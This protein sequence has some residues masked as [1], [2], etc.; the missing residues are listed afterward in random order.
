MCRVCASR[1]TT[2]TGLNQD[3]PRT[4]PLRW[5]GPRY[6]QLRSPGC[7]QTQEPEPIRNALFPRRS[8]RQ[9]FSPAP[10]ND[11]ASNHHNITGANYCPPPNQQGDVHAEGGQSLLFSADRIRLIRA[12][13][14]SSWPRKLTGSSSLLVWR[15]V[16]LLCP[17]G[18]RDRERLHRA[19]FCS[20]W[21]RGQD[22][23]PMPRT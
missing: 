5:P 1:A 16:A 2:G 8:V 22:S 9:S 10:V 3:A 11:F 18:C 21:S 15:A 4:G 19:V 14:I 12:V 17:D 13:G 20:P 7:G 23:Y 6:S